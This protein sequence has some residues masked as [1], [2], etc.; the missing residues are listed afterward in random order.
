MDLQQAIAICL[1][2]TFASFIQSAVGFAFSLFAVPSLLFCGLSLPEAVGMVIVVSICQRIWA[3]WHLRAAIDWRRIAPMVLIALC[4][5]PIGLFFM[6]RLNQSGTGLVKQVIGA[7]ILVTLIARWAWRVPPRDHVHAAWGWLAAFLGGVLSGLANIG[8]PPIVLWILAHKWSNEKMRVTVL[9]YSLPLSP[10]C[11]ILMILTFGHPV[12]AAMGRSVVFIPAALLGTWLG[13]HVGGR[14]SRER[15]RVL[16]QVFLL[17]LAL[18]AIVQPW[19]A[20][21]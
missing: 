11:G 19:L 5:I 3:T 2:L 13:L 1:I 20:A 4:G 10:V 12:V 17:L 8:G 9:A 21:G 18:Y 7:C 6:Y 14:I 16:A 15:L